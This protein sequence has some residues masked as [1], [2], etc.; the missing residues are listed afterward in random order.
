MATKFFAAVRG[1]GK[2]NSKKDY[3]AGCCALDKR[4]AILDAVARHESSLT[5]HSR[6]M[7]ALWRSFQDDVDVYDAAMQRKV[8]EAVS[9]RE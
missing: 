1:I 7:A 2:V 9:F 3:I 4:H 5:P 6:E 8:D